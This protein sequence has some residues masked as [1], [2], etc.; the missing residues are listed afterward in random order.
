MKSLIAF[1][2]KPDIFGMLVSILCLIHC[3]ITPLIFVVQA[4]TSTSSCCDD[5]PIWWSSIDYIFIMI[6]F[7]AIYWAN[8]TTTKNWMKYSLWVS[9]IFL[10]FVV[11]NEKM[12]WIY[13]MKEISYIPALVLVGLHVYNRNY[14]QKSECCN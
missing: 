5:T 14:C 2:K 10:S 12:E 13:L 1:I 7:F 9:W 3:L 4:C 11:L 8:K 6:S